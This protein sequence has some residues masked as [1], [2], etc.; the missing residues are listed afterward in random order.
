MV[1]RDGSRT[2][3]ATGDH[4]LKLY[5]RRLPVEHH[6]IDGPQREALY[7]ATHC[8]K[9]QPSIDTSP[10][11]QLTGPISLRSAHQEAVRDL[12]LEPGTAAIGQ[13]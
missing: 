8:E 2:A 6:W 4:R 11:G 13:R 9:L 7:Y 10:L 5:D 1:Q 12:V 3:A